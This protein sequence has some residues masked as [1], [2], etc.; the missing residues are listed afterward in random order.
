METLQTS[1][2]PNIISLPL[3]TESSNINSA[4]ENLNIEHVKK[5]FEFCEAFFAG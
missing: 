5:V 1:L 3:A 2:C 4:N